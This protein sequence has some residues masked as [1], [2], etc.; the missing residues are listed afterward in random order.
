MKLLITGSSGHLG[1]AVCRVLK[2][3]NIDYIGLDIHPGPFT[4]HLGSIDDRT[5]VKE[6]VSQVDYVLN[7]ATLHKPHVVTHSKHDFV[8][9]NI[10]GTLNLLEEAHLQHL[11]GF[12]FTSTT[13]T[14]GHVLTPKPGE[15]AVWT[16]EDTPYLPKNIY[17][18]TK[19]AAE[20]LCQLYAHN[21]NLPCL[22]LK[23]SRFFPED[24]DKKEQRDAYEELN[25]KANELL[26]RRVDIQDTVNAHLLALEKVREIGFGKYIISATSPF[27]KAHLAMLNTDAA[28]VI[29]GLFP[30]VNQLYA[31]KDW[32]L[33]QLIDRVYVNEKARTELGWNPKYDFKH[34]LNC[35]EQGLDFRSE[36]TLAVGAKGYHQEEFEEGPYP[37]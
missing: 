15:P 8:N 33:P 20:D 18:V 2:T 36:L 14:F 35:L 1:E 13:S 37:V 22:V 28:V 7:I 32:K 34:V 16:T 4:T 3:Q 6:L 23:T 10:I 9:V 21:H 19:I 11:K 31:E 5:L 24:D 29:R 30:Q 27:Q 12:I 25:L 26:Y 17:G